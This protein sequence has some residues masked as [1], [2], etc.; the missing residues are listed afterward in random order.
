VP[1][2]LEKHNLTVV[3]DRDREVAFRTQE[4]DL[5]FFIEVK[6][7]TEAV[8]DLF[9]GRCGCAGDLEAGPE[10]R[11]RIVTLR[12]FGCETA[13]AAVL[14]RPPVPLSTSVARAGGYTHAAQL[15]DLSIVQGPF[16]A[17][18]QPQRYDS[19]LSHRHPQCCGLI[20][21]SPASS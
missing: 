9:N 19:Q 11:L 3:L 13:H 14:R 17:P 21:V 5:A 10:V 6:Y 15:W 1:I 8:K 4:Q 7:C 12:N 18:C 16:S 2:D 20:Q